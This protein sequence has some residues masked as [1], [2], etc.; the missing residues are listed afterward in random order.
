MTINVRGIVEDRKRHKIFTWL[1]RQEV[2][3][4]LLQETHSTKANVAKFINSWRGES[5]YSLS[6]SAHS[7]GVGILVKRGIRN[8]KVVNSIKDDSGRTLLLNAEIGQNAITLVNVYA[9]NHIADRCEYFQQ[10]QTFILQ[11]SETNH[12][13]ILGGDFNCCLNNED[14]STNTHKDDKSRQVFQK[15]LNN[16]EMVDIWGVPNVSTYGHISHGKTTSHQADW[17]TSLHHNLYQLILNR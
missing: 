17:I 16:L 15:M 7:R 5:Y 10:L 12:S 1:S 3:V 4:I 2:D 11:N 8:F 6:S 9:P 13:L 14:R